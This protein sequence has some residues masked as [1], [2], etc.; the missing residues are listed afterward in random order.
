MISWLF[1]MADMFGVSSSKFFKRKA[2][3]FIVLAAFSPPHSARL[4][5]LK[6]FSVTTLHHWPSGWKTYGSIIPWHHQYGIHC[7]FDVDPTPTYTVGNKTRVTSTATL[8]VPRKREGCWMSRCFMGAQLLPGWLGLLLSALDYV[9]FGWLGE[10]L[11]W[12][13]KY[14][15]EGMLAFEVRNF[16]DRNWLDREGKHIPL[17]FFSRNY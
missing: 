8:F 17:C 3:L 11:S 10:G 9:N 16:A 14:C 2:N 4:Y 12:F 13:R 7:K 15:N 6:S 1:L 5:S